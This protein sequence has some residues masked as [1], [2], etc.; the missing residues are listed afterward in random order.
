MGRPERLIWGR[1]QGSA[2]EERGYQKPAESHLGWVDLIQNGGKV[3]QEVEDRM[4]QWA[5]R[6]RGQ[7]AW[8]PHSALVLTPFDFTCPISCKAE[9]QV[10][11]KARES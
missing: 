5:E 6:G 11:C 8:L 9:V 4:A 3:F 7:A 2:G 10:L 1:P